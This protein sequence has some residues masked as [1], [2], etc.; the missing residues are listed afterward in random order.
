[1]LAWYI[2]DITITMQKYGKIELLFARTQP[3][4]HYFQTAKWLEDIKILL[5]WIPWMT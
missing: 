2:N 5:N 3:V 4:I 1:M